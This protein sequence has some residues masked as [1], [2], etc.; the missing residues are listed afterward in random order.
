L[1]IDSENSQTESSR[2]DSIVK[3]IL[4]FMIEPPDEI[5]GTWT[6]EQ[7]RFLSLCLLVAVPIL[8]IAQIITDLIP[9]SIPVYSCAAA[10][11]FIAYIMS[12]AGHIKEAVI[13]LII[14]QNSI[15]FVILLSRPSWDP[16][17]LPRITVWLIISF[18]IG[19][20]LLHA[21]DEQ[22]FVGLTVLFFTL[23]CF[24]LYSIEISY[25][26]QHIGTL[27]IISVL[28]L[29]GSATL[30]RYFAR[31]MV[32]NTDLK[33]RKWELEVYAA[34][35]RH[36]LRNDLQA[37]N[38]G[39]ELSS[40]V[41]PI[42]EELAQEHL[43]RSLAVSE[44]IIRLIDAFS[45]P[46]DQVNHN[47]ISLIERI[48]A[49]AERTFE[50]ITIY[51]E[52]TNEAYEA[53]VTTSRLLPMVFDNLFRNAAQHSGENTAVTVSAKLEAD[54]IVVSVEDNGPGIPEVAKDWLFK[55]GKGEELTES[56]L[57]LYLARIILESHGGSIELA[58]PSSVSGA[59]FILTL[60]IEKGVV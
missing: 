50:N 40:M 29:V 27:T 25:L 32:Q 49:N 19:S 37:I 59:H 38:V 17:Y 33:R 41:F 1:A 57:G 24:L 56:G 31:V 15:P 44:R 54:Y 16:N 4:R 53:N 52:S 36:D 51:V 3:K 9:P 23:A 22:I 8:L 20:Y 14:C 6:R 5:E 43:Q 10:L 2:G 45:T 18:L 46:S 60:P 47:F 55:R 30:E 39:V 35:L 34:L 48:A 7:A 42:N 28:I 12:R 58:E 21:R 13:T 26:F 11:L